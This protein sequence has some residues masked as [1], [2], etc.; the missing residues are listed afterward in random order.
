MNRAQILTE[1]KFKAVRSS[2]AG[3]QHVNKVSSKVVAEWIPAESRALSEEEKALVL[4]RLQSR[5][6]KNGVLSLR[7]D[8]SR[9]QFKNKEEVTSR[10]LNLVEQALQVEKPRK[11]TKVPKRVVEKR[12]REKRSASETKQMRKRPGF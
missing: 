10:L 9:S 7:A 5:L 2:G 3:G 12:L 4:Q 8:G 6:N 11:P 1:L